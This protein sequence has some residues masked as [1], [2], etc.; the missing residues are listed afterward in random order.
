[1]FACEDMPRHPNGSARFTS[2]N[3]A[4]ANFGVRVLKELAQSILRPMNSIGG[5][6][7]ECRILKGSVI[8]L[9]EAHGELTQLI[10]LK[11]GTVHL[12]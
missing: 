7:N 8:R 3:E 2:R 4:L 6:V 9:L 1:M 10:A 11:Q 5:E 12:T